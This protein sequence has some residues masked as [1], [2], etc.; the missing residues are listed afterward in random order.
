MSLISYTLLEVGLVTRGEVPVKAAVD[1]VTPDHPFTFVHIYPAKLY[2][3]IS[4]IV[5]ELNLN[6]IQEIIFQ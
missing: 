5:H 3:T 6:I 1:G 4:S 2:F